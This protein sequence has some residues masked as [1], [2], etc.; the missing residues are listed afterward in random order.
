MVDKQVAQAYWKANLRLIVTCLVVWAVVGYGVS[1]FLREVLSGITFGG[2]DVGFWFSQQGSILT[3]IALVFF[4]AWRMNRIDKHF[5]M[6]E[7]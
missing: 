4:Y 5:G 1:I 2:V 3:F 6:S 7:D